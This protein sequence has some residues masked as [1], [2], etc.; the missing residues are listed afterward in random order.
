MRAALAGALDDAPRLAGLA[1]E[2]EQQLAADQQQFAADRERWQAEQ[3]LLQR[4][5]SQRDAELWRA[6]AES[7]AQT[8]VMTTSMEQIRQ[9]AAAE[10]NAQLQWQAKCDELSQQ[11][12]ASHAELERNAQTWHGERTSLETRFAEHSADTQRQLAELRQQ[13][14]EREQDLAAAA[15]RLK[16]SSDASARCDELQG[17]LLAAHQNLEAVNEQMAALSAT[18]Q[19][20]DNIA[21]QIA[22]LSQQRQLL[23]DQT[24]TLTRQREELIASEQ[25]LAGQREQIAAEQQASTSSCTPG[26]STWSSRQR[27]SNGTSKRP[28]PLGRA[29]RAAIATG[30]RARGPGP[31]GRAARGTGIANRCPRGG[32]TAI[33][34]GRRRRVAA[35]RLAIALAESETS[36]Q[37]LAEQVGNLELRCR[38]LEAQRGA[39]LAKAAAA[40]SE[41]A[42]APAD[43]DIAPHLAGLWMTSPFT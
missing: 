35:P 16:E 37:Q 23:D 21:R 29:G 8:G 27:S 24:A 28:A 14:A 3:T 1:A 31:A 7:T 15:N 32:P 42:A 34:A 10:H 38:E 5:L 12:A 13:L 22:D 9:E 26:S 18:S 20:Q 2:R 39:A 36:R 40:F 43:Q 6:A 17:K 30:R 41:Q 11:L 25:S 33:G 19:S 4:R